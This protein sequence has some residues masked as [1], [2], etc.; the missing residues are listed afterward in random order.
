MQRVKHRPDTPLDLTSF[1]DGIRMETK[2]N[3]FCSITVQLAAAYLESNDLP[4]KVSVIRE[5]AIRNNLTVVIVEGN[6]VF[7][8]MMRPMEELTEIL[9]ASGDAIC[10][11]CNYPYKH[12]PEES[13]P[14]DFLKVLCNGRRV[15]L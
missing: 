6:A 3:G 10:D 8:K 7:R 15:K 13:S 5:H 12:H 2:R 11:I 1:F 4:T 9:R 14:N